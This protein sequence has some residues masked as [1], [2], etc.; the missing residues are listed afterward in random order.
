MTGHTFLRAER[1][2]GPAVLAPA[3]APGTLLPP[4]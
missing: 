4:V 3:A 1:L 2:D